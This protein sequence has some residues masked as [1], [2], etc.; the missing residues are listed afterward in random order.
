M[1]S[2]LFNYI[3][4][5][6][7]QLKKESIKFVQ[8]KHKEESTAGMQT[9]TRGLFIGHHQTLQHYLEPTESPVVGQCAD[10]TWQ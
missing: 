1:R 9:V 8:W 3:S 7:K 5:S 2:M 6:M 4:C 10:E